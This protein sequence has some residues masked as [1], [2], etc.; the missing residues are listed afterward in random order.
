MV[1]DEK[2][3]PFPHAE[4]EATSVHDSGYG[5]IK[6]A[7]TDANG[8]FEIFDYPLEPDPKS[9]GQVRFEHPALLRAQIDNV[10]A[11]DREALK[12]LR[13]VLR[14]GHQIKGIV[15]TAGGRPAVRTLIE[16]IPADPH[17]LYKQQLTDA[18][19]RFLLEGLPDGD[20]VVRVDSF[21]SEQKARTTVRL[22]GADLEVNLRLEPLVMKNPITVMTL[23][24]MKLADITAELKAA[25]DLDDRANGVLI[26][27]P[28]EDVERLGI[29]R[30]KRE[31]TSGSSARNKSRTCGSSRRNSCGSM[32]STRPRTDGPLRDIADQCASFIPIGTGATR[33]TSS[34]R[35]RTS[36]D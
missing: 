1:V 26:I 29:R 2:G 12:S 6:F 9:V 7:E 28:G 33:S 17:A 30:R 8:R 5:Y 32:N 18:D 35:R 10:Y 13:I 20:L 19:G 3:Q 31:N 11:L 27:D 15:T 14:R 16:A 25:Y 24:G 4:V 36:S 23:F 22:Q 21:T 34:S